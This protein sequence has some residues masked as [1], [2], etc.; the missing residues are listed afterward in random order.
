MGHNKDKTVWQ[1]GMFL[2]PQ[3]FQQQERYF[4]KL[5]RQIYNI[6]APGHAGFSE[7]KIDQEQLRAG[8]FF[9]REARGI[10]PDGTPF[11]LEQHLC[12]DIENLNTGDHIYL[13]LPLMQSG[14]ADTALLESVNKSI[15]HVSYLQMVRDSV[16]PE[17]D[18]V[19]LELARLNPCLLTE[20]EPLD[21]YTTL[22]VARVQE[23][24]SNAELVLDSS[25]IP[26]CIDYRVS[27]YLLEQVQNL[28][29]MMQ[30]RASVIAAKI[31]IE[32]EQNSFQM[33]QVSYMWLQALNR[34]AVWLGMLEQQTG[35]SA[36]Q[37]YQDITYIAADLATFTSTMAP[38][39][40][41]YDEREIYA[42]FAP[43]LTSLRLNLKQA[44]KDKVIRLSWDSRLFKLRRLLRA[45]IED[46]TVFNDARFVLAVTSSIQQNQTRSL[47][48]S[49]AKL[50]GQNR[51]AERV[52]NA[53]SAVPITPLPIPPIELKG[54]P[55]T[56]YFEVDT[57][58]AL[59]LEMVNTRDLLALHVDEQM[60]ED[61]H[62]DCFIIR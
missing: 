5:S 49:A 2:S 7:L 23:C 34:Y 48:V 25:Y 43:V 36:G 30:Q 53:L 33:M 3:H 11:E 35:V 10:F 19:Q 16:N 6:L 31:G 20:G 15:R 50:C 59:W 52:R 27:H 37:L 44:S 45:V 47:F 21:D 28:K 55:N 57:S 8:K 22:A 62:I 26:R 46:R 14:K 32:G 18:P 12:R 1:E 38:E 4:E 51:I 40:P 61:T 17:N 58:D 54:K 13:A 39:F 24:R 41:P 60:P 29:T 42:S 56:V 9:V